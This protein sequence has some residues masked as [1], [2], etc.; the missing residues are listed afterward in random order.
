MTQYPAPQDMQYLADQNRLRQRVGL[1][2]RQIAHL[3]SGTVAVTSATH[4]ASPVIGQQ[5]YETDTGDTYIWTGSLWRWISS[6]PQEWDIDLISGTMPTAANATDTAPAFNTLSYSTGVSVSL[7]TTGTTATSGTIVTLNRA[8]RYAAEVSLRWAVG[9]GYTYVAIRHYSSGSI[10][11]ER[12]GGGANTSGSSAVN[13]VAMELRAAAG[14][15]A[16]VWVYQVT[17]GTLALDSGAGGSRF[18]GH[19]LHP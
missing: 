13:T 4:P 15:Y 10:E 8:G 14:D 18:S 7:G 9:T 16:A 19:Y 2:E 17:G 5:I 6:P 1:L 3:T 11:Q 12:W